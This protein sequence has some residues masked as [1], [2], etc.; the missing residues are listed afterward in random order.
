MRDI[1]AEV[2]EGT[3]AREWIQENQANRPSYGQLYEAER[4][5]DIERVGGRLRS[6][7]AWAD[8]EDAA[9]EGEGESES[10]NERVRADD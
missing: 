7:F 1:L 8:E 10:E 2:Q 6:L 3:F 4:T 9:T 5:H